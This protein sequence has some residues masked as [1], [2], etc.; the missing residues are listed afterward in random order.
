MA[1]SLL[2]RLSVE[3]AEMLLEGLLTAY[4]QQALAHRVMRSPRLTRRAMQPWVSAT[5]PLLAHSATDADLAWLLPTLLQWAVARLRPDQRSMTDPLPQQAWLG[6]SPWRPVVALIGHYGFQPVPQFAQH[7]RSRQDESPADRI[8]GLWDVAPSSFYRQLERGRR[9]LLD[10]LRQPL[11]A[12]LTLSWW[13][14]AAQAMLA[15]AGSTMATSM[16]EPQRLGWHRQ[17]VLAAQAQDRPEAALW[18]ALQTREL[19]LAADVL[20]RHAQPLAAHPLVEPMLEHGLP[21]SIAEGAT[22]RA[23]DRA[24]LALAL[25][26]LARVRGDQA[27]EFDRYQQALRLASAADDVLMLGL[28]R[29]ALGR[30]FEAR[31]IDRAFIDYRSAAEHLEQTL[32]DEASEGVALTDRQADREQAE[33]AYLSVLV[34]LGWL[35]MLRNDPLAADVLQRASEL[36]QTMV[37]PADVAA[38]FEQAWGEYWRRKGNLQGAIDATWRA[39]QQYE[40]IGNRLQ[41]L[42]SYSN[43]A[44]MYGE[45]QQF[46]QAIRYSTMVLQL[47]ERDPLDPETRAGTHL[48]LG[49]A[50]FWQQRYDDA[51]DHYQQG[52]RVAEAA[53]M[54]TIQGRAHFN[55]AEAY[56]K[57]FQ[58][59]GL[60]DDERLGDA[61]VGLALR[62]WERDGDAAASEATRNLKRT[63]LGQR[64]HLVYDQLL[65]GEVAA[66]AREMNEIQQQRSRLAVPL[67]AQQQIEARLA[68]ARAYLSIA[69]QEREAA[70]ALMHQHDLQANFSAE[71]QTMRALFDREQSREEHLAHDWLQRMPGL[72]SEA[73]AKRLAQHLLT[74]GAVGKSRYAELCSVSPAT[75]SKHLSVMADLGLLQRHG[76]GP[77][78]HYQLGA[79]G[80]SSTQ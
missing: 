76:R 24:L 33:P 44:L 19:A 8:C 75:A 26:A 2:H 61:H 66:Y 78:T 71:L 37:A 38:T 11:D 53:S 79:N 34:R 80:A 17:Q 31:D 70:M 57:R 10:A 63:V 64:Q 68:M 15:Q 69:M 23:R 48:N 21:K 67:P 45:A 12:S 32:R 73:Q 55:L 27:A 30:Y 74:E 39:L 7:Y 28:T 20:Q 41:V 47:G 5:Q 1:G 40:A 72:L 46:D 35:Y 65:P 60:P 4:R 58:T 22:T 16:T 36:R 59:S 54:G 49:V 29:Q 25:G 3:R 13:D 43:L 77:M 14:S 9:M 50:L 56:Y 18:H 52:L 6:L 42:R 62:V 51:I